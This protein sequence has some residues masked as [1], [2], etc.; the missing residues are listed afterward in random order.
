MGAPHQNKAWG[1]NKAIDGNPSQDCLSYSCAITDVDE[2]LNTSIWWKVW[3]EKQF[4]VAFLEIYFRSDSEFSK[5][6]LI[7]VVT[8]HKQIHILIFANILPYINLQSNTNVQIGL[9]TF[10]KKL[11]YMN[12][13]KG[14]NVQ[15]C[16]NL[17]IT[18]R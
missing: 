8:P 6:N 3:L 17:I 1:A 15:S 4:N 5:N 7:L 10:A 12:L 13:Q 2:N 9:F 18:S 16:M 14:K 11:P